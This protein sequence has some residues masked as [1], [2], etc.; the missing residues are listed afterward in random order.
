MEKTENKIWF[1]DKLVDPI[2]HRP[3]FSLV[4]VSTCLTSLPFSLF[5]Y[6]FTGTHSDATI[7]FPAQPPSNPPTLCPYFPFFSFLSPFL[8]LSLSC[9][10]EVSGT[11]SQGRPCPMSGLLMPGLLSGTDNSVPAGDRQTFS[12]SDHKPPWWIGLMCILSLFPSTAVH[13]IECHT[14]RKTGKKEVAGKREGN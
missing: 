11:V 8:A 10:L 2:L 3:P 4:W 13:Y 1:R 12:A 14:K 5:M 6:H 9:G 7:L